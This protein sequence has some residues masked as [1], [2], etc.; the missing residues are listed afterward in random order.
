[1]SADHPFWA[2]HAPP[3]GWGC[4]CYVSG[5]RS[6]AG[7]K[8]LGGIPGKTLPEGWQ[9]LDPRTGA[10]VGISKG[11]AYAPGASVASN[12][13][14][15]VAAKLPSLPPKLGADMVAPLEDQVD[16][17]WREWVEA[18]IKGQAAGPG[19]LGTVSSDVVAALSSRGLAPASAE[20]MVRPGLLF[21]PKAARHEAA[22]DSIPAEAWRN[23]SKRIRT[24]SAVLFDESSGRILFLLDEGAGSASQ[25]ALAL[26]Y[27][28]KA[29]REIRT[30]NVIVSAYRPKT[31]DIVG[32]IA[33][34]LLKVL[35]GQV[36]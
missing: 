19:L 2:T 21:G 12:I 30:A 11:W 13:I 23:L 28:L 16:E 9:A 36:G 22:A 7:A 6:E 25:F 14:Q 4:T 3:N 24:P 32:R 8:R 5:A 26:D 27:R 15:T 1:M 35:L 34:G 20:V 17:A 10:P 33:G 29:N 18:A 31:V